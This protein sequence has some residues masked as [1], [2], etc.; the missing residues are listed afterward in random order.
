MKILDYF[1]AG[2]LEWKTQRCGK[3]TMSHGKE[4]RT[5]GRGKTRQNYIN[6]IVAEVLSGQMTEGYYN[7]DMERGNYLEDVAITIFC[8]ATELDA[9]TVGLVLQDDERIACTPD[10]LV[11]A[12]AGLE[13]KC[14]R[15]RKHIHNVFG[16]GI[17]DYIDQAQGGMWVCERDHWYIASF[18]PWVKEYPFHVER[19]DRDPEI[20]AEI[21]KSAI[22]AADQVE[23]CVEMARKKQVDPHIIELSERGRLAWENALADKDEVIL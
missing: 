9:K 1:E 5:R 12:D 14:P 15:P 22:D 2:S 19:V 10:A 20:I 3:I 11:G 6:D 8:I 23:K 16:D 21:R 17:S 13:I 4:L 18:C 7:A